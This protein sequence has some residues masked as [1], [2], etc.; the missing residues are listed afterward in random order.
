MKKVK[1]KMKDK[2]K[3]KGKGC[4]PEIVAIKKTRIVPVAVPVHSTRPVYEA[5]EPPPSPLPAAKAA[6]SYGNR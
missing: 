4:V 2:M 1:D 6:P 3:D 5:D